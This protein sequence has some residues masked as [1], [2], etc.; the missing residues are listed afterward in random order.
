MN[1][2]SRLRLRA[3][4]I[5]LSSLFLVP[6][7]L[8]PQGSLTPPGAPAPTMK[9]LDQVEA[10]THLAGG[11]SALSVGSGSYYLTGNLTISSVQ[12][13]ITIT[14]S[15]VTIDLNGFSVTGPGSGSSA[16]IF[17]NGGVSNVTILNGTIRDWGGFGINAL[18]NPNLRVE[19]L[20]VLS[21]GNTG[22]TADAN[23]A[24]ILCVL[25]SNVNG[26]I[27]GL[28][29]CVVKDTQAIFSTT[30]GGTGISLGAA[31]V[32]TGCIARGNGGNGIAPGPGSL[33]HIK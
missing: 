11:S 30:L 29:N 33:E 15:N 27:S 3:T 20:R 19:K 7:S 5:A 32:V 28:D 26:G 8:F 13:G 16:G 21:N 2:P 9:T 24:V 10:R 12:N 17:L 31:A 14:A 22:I 25:D 1:A 4:L 23:A 6:C 18:G